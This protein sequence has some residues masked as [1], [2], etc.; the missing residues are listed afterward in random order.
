MGH[1]LG[2]SLC[3]WHYNALHVFLWKG[4]LDSRHS[5]GRG[6]HLRRVLHQLQRS[7]FLKNVS[8]FEFCYSTA[9]S[10]S[11]LAEWDSRSLCSEFS[12]VG[13]FF[14]GRAL[15]PS[16]DPLCHSL[17]LQSLLT[18]DPVIAKE[19]FAM[20]DFDIRVVF[21]GFVRFCASRQSMSILFV[22][23][24]AFLSPGR[25]LFLCIFKSVR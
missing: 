21:L 7:L 23:R 1:R 8:P 11:T 10:Q 9:K 22:P 5:A 12:M 13:A 15:P 4:A 18:T 16:R 3:T 6:P 25:G 2:S 17:T 14:L 24:P 20:V 19:G